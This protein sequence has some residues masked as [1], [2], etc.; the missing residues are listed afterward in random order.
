MWERRS[1]AVT[2]S[3]IEWLE[4]F[5]LSQCDG[6]WEHASGCT[7]G[8][9]DNPGWEFGFDLEDTVLEGVP[10]PELRSDRSEDDWVM[11]RVEEKRWVGFG[12]PRNLNQIIG[13]FRQW[14]EK[15]LA[16]T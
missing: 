15:V 2:A 10:F 4:E 8:T 1:M 6:D 7:I 12:G 16:A 14:V 5:Y 13:C 3:N 11:C 9:L